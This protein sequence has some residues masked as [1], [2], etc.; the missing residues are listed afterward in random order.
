[1]VLWVLPTFYNRKVVKIF[2]LAFKRKS[3]YYSVIERL[4]CIVERLIWEIPD[5]MIKRIIRK[6]VFCIACVLC[7]YIYCD[8]DRDD[9]DHHHHDHDHDSSQSSL[10][11]EDRQ[12]EYVVRLSSETLP[13]FNDAVLKNP[14]SGG[15][16]PNDFVASMCEAP[17]AVLL[18]WGN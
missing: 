9:D 16:T 3:Q 13:L 10:W 6:G 17:T 11:Q 1:L 14:A 4:G 2:S 18:G 7:N 12:K 8:F 15:T 5:N